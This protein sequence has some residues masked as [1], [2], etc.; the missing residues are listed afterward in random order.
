M[1]VFSLP[2]FFRYTGGQDSRDYHSQTPE[3]VAGHVARKD[4]GLVV[5]G[6]PARCSAS[7]CDTLSRRAPLARIPCHGARGRRGDAS[8]HVGLGH[9]RGPEEDEQAPGNGRP[10]KGRARGRASQAGVPQGQRPAPLTPGFQRP[11]VQTR[12]DPRVGRCVCFLA[13]TAQ[14]AEGG[15]EG[16]ENS[17]L[18][19]WM[20]DVERARR[21]DWGV[22]D[23]CLHVFEGPPGGRGNR[24]L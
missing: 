17:I 16:G 1:V 14:L 10:R 12:M 9:L 15:Q 22:S 2:V 7:V 21:A 18:V 8:P 3:Q 11:W 4:A 23:S 20:S 13:P 19:L 24:F 6:G 5:V